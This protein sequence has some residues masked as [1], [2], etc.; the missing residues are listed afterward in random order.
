MG[1]LP[2]NIRSIGISRSHH[3]REDWP[4]GRWPATM[5]SIY[6]QRSPM[7]LNLQPPI[8]RVF[9]D[10][11]FYGS[12]AIYT[13]TTGYSCLRFFVVTLSLILDHICWSVPQ[14]CWSCCCSCY[15]CSPSSSSSFY[16]PILL[17]YLPYWPIYLWSAGHVSNR[18]E[19]SPVSQL[20]PIPK[21][22]ELLWTAAGLYNNV[23]IC[24]PWIYRPRTAV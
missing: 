3:T 2:S 11:K 16:I 4:R 24:Q 5:G 14:L 15:C 22:S 10:R 13:F 6:H 9:N 18:S 23:N 17:A 8:R 1:P 19:L 20:Q 7:W 12:V 21:G